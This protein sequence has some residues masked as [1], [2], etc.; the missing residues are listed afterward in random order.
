MVCSVCA[1]VQRV[2]F[3][4]PC[5]EASRAEAAFPETRWSLP[6]RKRP[7][8]V[9]LRVDFPGGFTLVELL[10]VIAII[11][12]LIA[13]LLP[14]VQ[15]AR[16]AARRSQCSN[17]LKQIILATHTYHDVN[18]ALPPGSTLHNPIHRGNVFLRL[19][20]F[21]EQKPLYDEISPFFRTVKGDGLTPEDAT[22]FGWGTDT[23]TLSNGQ[24][25]GSVR[26]AA[27]QC[28]SDRYTGQL[29]KYA[30]N[31]TE[32]H[33]CTYAASAGPTADSNLVGYGGCSDMATYVTYTHPFE[34]SV[35]FWCCPFSWQGFER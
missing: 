31:W 15:A 18:K 6:P 24:A 17:N 14:A 28:P 5:G 12:I 4:E 33:P 35:L 23:I 25:L 9:A 26:I 8:S 27:L 13:L 19:L 3:D 29:V 32:A 21:M 2:V 20:P 7:G 16:E 30:D 34:A 22:G 1:V 11:G 10:V